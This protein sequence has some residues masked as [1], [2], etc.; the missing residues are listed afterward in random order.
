MPRR[1]S[2]IVRAM[3]CRP[4]ARLGRR[5]GCVRRA[6][7]SCRAASSRRCCFRPFRSSGNDADIDSAANAL[8]YAALALGLNIVVGLAG[9]LDLGYA[10]FFAIGAYTYGVAASWQ[11]EPA[12][13][14]FWEPFQWLGLVARL[15]EAGGDVV[16]FQVSF[17]LMMP[18]VGGGDGVFRRAVRRPDPAAQ[19]RLP[20][21][22]HLRLRRDR[23]DR[24]AQH[25]ER[26]QRRDGA[27]RR[28]RAAA[29]RLE[30]RR[31]RDALL[32]CRARARRAC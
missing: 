27:Q 32:L 14:G 2:P 17:W 21:D 31:Q 29:F 10:A 15:H 6:S 23:A 8:T 3:L 16:H 12:W 25:A 7:P 26:H 19:G 4:P 24:R 13:S 11:I 5:R 18:V 28:R 22:R 1:R 20:G 30:L 9:L